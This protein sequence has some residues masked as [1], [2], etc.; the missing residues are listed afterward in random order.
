MGI[1]IPVI[2]AVVSRWVFTALDGLKVHGRRTGRNAAGK[3][4]VLLADAHVVERQA[5]AL[6]ADAGEMLARYD[7][8]I[9]WDRKQ[10]GYGKGVLASK[11]AASQARLAHWTL[12]YGEDFRRAD[13]R[14][15]LAKQALATA[16]QITRRA[17]MAAAVDE[18]TRFLQ[19][20]GVSEAD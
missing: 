18:P 6:L 10:I 8:V 15:D 4:L 5:R 17:R 16:L 11:I 20:P 9:S 14:L 19:L 12:E 7:A 13:G 3:E 1:V 2:L